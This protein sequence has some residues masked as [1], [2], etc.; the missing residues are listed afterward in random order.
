[1]RRK[2]EAPKLQSNRGIATELLAKLVLYIRKQTQ[3]KSTAARS[4]R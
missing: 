3:R 2:A 1:M 4:F